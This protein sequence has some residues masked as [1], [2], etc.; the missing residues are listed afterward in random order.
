[1]AEPDTAVLNAASGLDGLRVETESGTFLGH[2]FD[3]RCRWR[4]GDDAS[5][6]HEIVFGRTGFLLRL[7]IATRAPCT[8]PWSAV[9]AVRPGVIVVADGLASPAG[10]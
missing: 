1:M 6:V 3:L 9:K 5:A 7:G 2:L 4:A 8:L 10:R